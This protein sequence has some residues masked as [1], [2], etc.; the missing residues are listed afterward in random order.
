MMD[1]DM[2]TFTFFLLLLFLL[3]L[4]ILLPEAPIYQCFTNKYT[5]FW[6]SKSQ[7]YE[8]ILVSTFSL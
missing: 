4:N 5:K 8:I 3:I 1:T 6:I 7:I 2:I